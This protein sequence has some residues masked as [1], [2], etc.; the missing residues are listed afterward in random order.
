MFN[1]FKL[2]HQCLK[3]SWS[4]STQNSLCAALNS[5]FYAKVLATLI[6]E[7]KKNLDAIYLFA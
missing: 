7:S 1:G 4:V 6:E 5:R 2:R 3:I